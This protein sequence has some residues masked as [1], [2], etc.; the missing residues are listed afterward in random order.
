MT[1]TMKKY[2]FRFFHSS[3]ILIAYLPSDLEGQIDR[4]LFVL[5]NPRIL[6]LLVENFDRSRSNRKLIE[7]QE[8][9]SDI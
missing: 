6:S 3:I 5:L 9:F 2:F 7:V 1:R 8:N 4:P